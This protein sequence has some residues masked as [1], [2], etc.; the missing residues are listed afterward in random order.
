MISRFGFGLS[1]KLRVIVSSATCKVSPPRYLISNGG[2][3]ITTFRQYRYFSDDFAARATQYNLAQPD[4]VRKVAA[5][6][7]VIW[8][9]VRTPQEIKENGSFDEAIQTTCTLESCP[10]LEA[11]TDRVLST[12]NKDTPI[13]LYCRTGRRATKAKEVLNANG[14][15]NVINAGGWD[16]LTYLR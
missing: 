11:D 14:Y 6:P 5:L 1:T 8:L 10:D 15:H 2:T 7:N 3:N 4:E 9:D 13:I 16:D 12:K